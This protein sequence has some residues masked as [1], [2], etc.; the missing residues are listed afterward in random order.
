MVT[1]EFHIFL[2]HVGS[3]SWVRRS[4]LDSLIHRVVVFKGQVFGMHSIDG[5][6]KV[7]LVPRIRLQNISVD[8]GKSMGRLK[9][10]KMWLVACGDMLLMVGCPSSVPS[11]GDTLEAFRLDLSVQRAK[12][13]KVEKLENWA[14]FI[15]ID[16][17]S[18]ALCCMDPEKWGGRSNCIYYYDSKEWIAC[19]LGKPL[20]VGASTPRFEC[21]HMMQPMWVVPSMFYSFL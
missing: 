5:L 9:D 15:S 17:R 14:I 8:L 2:W 11:I 3:H 21:A 16:G 12:W 20:K 19:E 18:Q 6:F 4:N 10:A 1:T 13:V 7:H